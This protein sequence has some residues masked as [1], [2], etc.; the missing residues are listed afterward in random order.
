MWRYPSP[1]GRDM[2]MET[3]MTRGYKV[4][5][6]RGTAPQLCDFGGKHGRTAALEA[7]SR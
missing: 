1:Y 3:T 2:A 7:I 6:V 4:Q 5:A